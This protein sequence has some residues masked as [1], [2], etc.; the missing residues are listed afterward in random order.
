MAA[1]HTG[2]EGLCH[3]LSCSCP[4]ESNHVQL[5]HYTTPTTLYTTLDASQ[6]LCYHQTN[7]TATPVM[8]ALCLRH[9]QRMS[10]DRLPK[11]II[12]G[13]LTE[14]IKF[15]PKIKSDILTHLY[16]SGLIALSGDIHPNHTGAQFV[17]VEVV[18]NLSEAE[19]RLSSA[20]NVINGTTYIVSVYPHH[21]TTP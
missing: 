1:A 13:E 20:K 16:L 5:I 2:G 11:S 18:L 12:Y 3:L 10:N 9:V 8:V 6:D 17:L 4:R 21:P 19:T 15:P 14:R 7:V